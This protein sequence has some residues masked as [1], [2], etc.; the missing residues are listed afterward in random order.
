MKRP[1][2]VIWEEHM[3]MQEMQ[4]VKQRVKRAWQQKHTKTVGGPTDLG[5]ILYASSSSVSTK[6][7]MG[8]PAERTMDVWKCLQKIT[9]V[10]GVL[11]K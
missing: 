9:R 5:A 10:A 11:R 4:M 7:D 6:K 8:P 3:V 2:W 1:F